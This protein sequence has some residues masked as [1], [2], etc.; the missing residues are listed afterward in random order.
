MRSYERRL[1]RLESRLR[2]A[3]DTALSRYIAARL[4]AA[5]RRCGLPEPTERLAPIRGKSIVALLNEGRERARAAALRSASTAT[6]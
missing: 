4:E 3:A 5:R 1:R 2:P 6:S